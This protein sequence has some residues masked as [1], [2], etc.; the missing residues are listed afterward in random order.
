MGLLKR[1]PTECNNDRR[2]AQRLA[3][4]HMDTVRLTN[5]VSRLSATLESWICEPCD[6]WRQQAQSQPDASLVPQK[7]AGL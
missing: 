1:L 4:K 6:P 5:E 3:I 7:Q 2:R